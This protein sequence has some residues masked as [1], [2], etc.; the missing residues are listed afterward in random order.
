MGRMKFE[1]AMTDLETEYTVNKRDS[2]EHLKRRIKLHL[3]PWFRG[4]RMT[5][6]TTADVNAYVQRRQ[7]QKRGRGDHQPRAGDPEARVHPRD[8]GR[9]AAAG[10]PAVHR[11]APGA[12][13]PDG[14]LRGGPV[15]GG[16]GAAAGGAPSRGRVRVSH[17]LAR[18]LGGAAARMAARRPEGRHRH[19][20]PRHD[21]ERRG[22]DP[23]Y[24]TAA[25]R[26]LLEAQKAASEALAK[27]QETDHPAGVPSPREA[28]PRAST[29][30]GGTRARRPAVPASSC[31]TSGGRRSA[32][33]SGPASPNGW[34][35]R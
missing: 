16:E 21:E 35:W 29:R 15:R 5:K 23:I 34:R 24:V 18:A 4:R 20:G 10:A 22:A 12:Q 27:T 3:K 32:T 11:H 13:R 19:A 28:D 9:Q 26:T 17:R 1:E 7:E 2:L 25:L 14:V 30:R 6:I 31:T 33:T 8:P